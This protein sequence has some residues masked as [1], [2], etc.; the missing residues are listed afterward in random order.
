MCVCMYISTTFL[1]TPA[2]NAVFIRAPAI[3]KVGPDVHVL[4]KVKARPSVAAL[5]ALKASDAA[6]A[7]A[8]DAPPPPPQSPQSSVESTATPSDDGENFVNDFKR[9]T[10]RYRYTKA[11][12][13]GGSLDIL[14]SRSYIFYY[15]F[16]ILVQSVTALL[17][18]T[19]SQRAHFPCSFF[20]SH[21]VSL[22]L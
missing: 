14:A 17:S 20:S 5:A 2:S 11:T 10:P 3:M 16:R 22:L 19:S 8:K 1:Q 7:A 18:S 13:T 15:P 4:A 9:H 12:H 6:A 21:S